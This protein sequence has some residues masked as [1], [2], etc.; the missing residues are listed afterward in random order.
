[1]NKKAL[2]TIMAFL[3]VSSF[4]LGYSAE[5]TVN[6]EAEK[7]QPPPHGEFRMPPNHRQFKHPSKEE[8]EKKKA[9]FD[10]RLNLTEEQKKQ[11][12]ENRKIGHEKVKP[13][14]E[15]KRAIFHE[16]KEIKQNNDLSEEQKQKKID[17]LKSD[18]KKLD[19]QANSLRQENMKAFEGILN[20]KQKKEFEKIKS[21]QKKEMEKRKKNFE[22]HK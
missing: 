1:M 4:S 5:N 20:N 17:S 13:I 11:I 10:K 18:I 12:E 3:T 8:M 14:F 15:Q 22:K 6:K 21:E 2:L 7:I 9:E 16:I 19:E